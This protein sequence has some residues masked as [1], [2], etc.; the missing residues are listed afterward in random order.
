MG[1]AFL[2]SPPP[3]HLV[4]TDLSLLE[5]DAGIAG[6]MFAVL[7]LAEDLSRQTGLPLMV[8]CL[9]GFFKW[10]VVPQSF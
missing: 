10:T 1:E 4:R 5:L 2:F 3:S 7:L 6:P 8:G 9:G